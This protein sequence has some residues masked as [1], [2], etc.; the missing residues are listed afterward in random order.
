MESGTPLLLERTFVT[1]DGYDLPLRV[2]PAAGRERAVVLA[3]HGFNDYSNGIDWPADYWAR[4]GIT[5]YAYDQRGFGA[6][7]RA[8]LW[9]G[10][11]ALARDARD[12]AR[13]LRRRHPDRP[14]FLFGESMGG[15]IAIAALADGRAPEVDGLILVAPAVWARS[16]MNPLYRLTLWLAAHTFPGQTLTGRGLGIRPSDN[17]E[18]LRAFSRDPL[19]IKETRI[20]AI[21]GLVNMMDLGLERAAALHGVPTLILYGDRDELIP[22][23]PIERMLARMPNAPRVGR[24]PSGF[25][26]L[27]RDLQAPLVWQDALDW[28]LNPDRPLPSGFETWRRPLYQMPAR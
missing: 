8:G 14:L 11:G 4:Y 3:L 27:T 10:E 26:M 24:Y 18:M 7:P 5:T 22:K 25:H 19:V 9:G 17:I 21:W 16:T 6:G 13:L 20:D 12:M 23:T 15:A 2:W 1:S 28:M